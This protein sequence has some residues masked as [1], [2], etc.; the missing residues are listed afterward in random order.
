MRFGAGYPTIVLRMMHLK[1]RGRILVLVILAA[2]P[3]L[4]LMVYSA[5]DRRAAAADQARREIARIVR[6]AARQQRQVIEGARQMMA[7]SAEILSMLQNDR[8]R[9]REYF[10]SLLNQNRQT[11]HSMGLFLANGNLFCNAATWQDKTTYGGDR[12]YFR[13]AKE[14][15]K[16]TVGEYQIGRVTGLAGINFGYPVTDPEH[17]LT[18][19]VFAG[20]DLESLGR[21]A[22]ATPLPP[23]GVLNVFDVE[24]IIVAHK[25]AAAGTI[26][27][28]LK[29]AEVVK[30]MLDGREGVFEAKGTDGVDRLFAHEVVI[31]NPDGA[32]PLRVMVSVPLNEVFADA[33]RALIR[34][35]VGL[36]VATLFLLIG[37]WYGAGLFVIRKIEALVSAA[38][39]MRAGDLNARTGVRYGEEELGQLARAFDDM[40]QALQ[41]REQDLLEQAITDPLTGLY[42]RR[43][44]KELL[45]REFVRGKR[46]GESIALILADIDHFKRVNDT[47]GHE[48]GDKVLTTVGALIKGNVRGSDIACRYGGEEFALVLPETG[49][50]AAQR[51]AEDIRLALGQLNLNYLG[52]P[53]GRITISLGI[54]LFPEHGEDMNTL[55]RAADEAL[56]DAKGAGRDRV[57][58]STEEK[59]E[60]I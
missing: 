11:Y 24:G 19:V 56:Y 49:T 3:A 29:R 26:G 55:L 35:L 53:I 58:V 14:T 46:S 23:G 40:A 44:L 28:K 1:T 6:L 7:A 59:A 27:V 45:P 18:G 54:A 10:R 42:N 31:Q 20:L 41:Q 15:R 34:D 25:P 48:A 5:V 60:R 17:N 2:L 51:R 47:F 12:L 9:C 30:E 37:A 43:Y 22:E 39:R 52:K 36:I 50:E 13:L 16:F 33:N 57:V 4:L 32:Y 38:A 8:R 21:M